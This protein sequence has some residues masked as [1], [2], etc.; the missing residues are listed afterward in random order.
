MNNL[1]KILE[2]YSTVSR[3]DLLILISIILDSHDNKYFP[4]AEIL[5]NWINNCSKNLFDTLYYLNYPSNNVLKSI[6]KSIDFFKLINTIEIYNYKKDNVFIE[7]LR[8]IGTDI[9]LCEYSQHFIDTDS[10]PY[11]NK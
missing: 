7:G 1:D 6:T 2:Q 9:I 4:S 8:I 11:Y 5:E 10:G 3:D